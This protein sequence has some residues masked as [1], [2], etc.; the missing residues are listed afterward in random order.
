MSV[1]EYVV[2]HLESYI[3]IFVYLLTGCYNSL[4]MVV[5][6]KLVKAEFVVSHARLLENL[7]HL[8]KTIMVLSRK[9][10]SSSKSLD[11]PQEQ[12]TF[13]PNRDNIIF[14]ISNP[15]CEHSDVLEEDIHLRKE[16]EERLA[17]LEATNGVEG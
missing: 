2:T 5:M 4:V 11:S 7:E 10:S 14:I 15:C 16:L 1:E 17:F 9:F 8:D 3:E 13:Q 6:L 12:P